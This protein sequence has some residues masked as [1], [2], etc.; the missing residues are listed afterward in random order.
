MTTGDT[1]SGPPHS[2]SHLCAL[3]GTRPALSKRAQRC[4]FTSVETPSLLGQLCRDALPQAELKPAFWKLPPRA[5][6]TAA[7]GLVRPFLTLR[8]CE[9]STML[10]PLRLFLGAAPRICGMVVPLLQVKKRRSVV[11]RE[12]ESRLRSACLHDHCNFPDWGGGLGRHPPAQ[13]EGPSV[14]GCPR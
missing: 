3:T 8:G 2:D 9:E 5:C 6:M 14:P 12:S 7:R 11:P 1:Q 13:R 4:M 10:Y